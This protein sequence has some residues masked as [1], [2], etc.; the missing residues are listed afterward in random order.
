MSRLFSTKTVL[1]L[2]YQTTLVCRQ[3]FAALSWY[4]VVY[5]DN[6]EP[7]RVCCSFLTVLSTR[8]PHLM[9]LLIAAVQT[10]VSV[11]FPCSDRVY[12][13]PLF[14]TCSICIRSIDEQVTCPCYPSEVVC[15]DWSHRDLSFILP[16]FKFDL[17][18]IV[19]VRVCSP[20]NKRPFSYC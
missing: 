5:C 17:H 11:S 6:S 18:Y 13:G 16:H 9:R 20:R 10:A 12:D 4:M 1:C 15:S 8:Q 3:I 14:H 2:E 19:C 7:H